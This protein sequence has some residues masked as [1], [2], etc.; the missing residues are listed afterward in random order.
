MVK[1]FR[2][3]L[4]GAETKHPVTKE[5]GGQVLHFC[6]AGCWQVYELQ[7]DELSA[8]AQG[9]TVSRQQIDIYPV[10]QLPPPL[11]E[12]S[13]TETITLPIIGMTCASCVSHVGGALK[14]LGGVEDA[15]VDLELG[16]ASVT[17]APALVSISVMRQAVRKAGYGSPDPDAGP[18]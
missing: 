13:P 6:C 8:P 15:F 18:Q 5:I 4:C 7:R 9:G 2:C 12:A 11:Q 10:G 17:Y 3:G 14:A 16:T 1:T